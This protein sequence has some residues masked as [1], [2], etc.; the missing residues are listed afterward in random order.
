YDNPW[1]LA[2]LDA[3]LFGTEPPCRTRAEAVRRFVPYARAEL[4]RGTP[5]K[6]M[7][8][9]L[10]GLFAGRPGARLWRRSLGLLPNGP[11][12]LAEL[13]ALA[14]ALTDGA[15]AADARAASF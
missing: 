9:H 2:E 12:G 11:A 14:D 7:T 10:L 5:L 15:V 6:A 13:E 4:A 3:R 8:R 1:S